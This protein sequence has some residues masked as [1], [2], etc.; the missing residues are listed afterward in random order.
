MW[1]LYDGGRGLLDSAKA[2]RLYA[3]KGVG[4]FVVGA[5]MGNR[6]DGRG[7][8][9]GAY[10]NEDTAREILVEIGYGIDAGRELFVM[11]DDKYDLVQ[12][13]KRIHDSRVKRRGGS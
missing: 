12:P 11:P 4:A 13:E 2:V 1:I 9:L 5:D 6:G 10:L 3:A 7:I 8:V